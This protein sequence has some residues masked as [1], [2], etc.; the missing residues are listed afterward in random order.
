MAR[1]DKDTKE[2]TH[3]RKIKLVKINLICTY[4]CIITPSLKLGYKISAERNN[5]NNHNS[6]KTKTISITRRTITETNNQF[7]HNENAKGHRTKCKYNTVE[8]GAGAVT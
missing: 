5:G 4:N 7:K 1:R 2:G 6:V 3:T 8:S